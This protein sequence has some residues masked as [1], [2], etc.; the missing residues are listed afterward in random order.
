MT[1]ARCISALSAFGF[2]QRRRARAATPAFSQRGQLV[3]AALAVCF[4]GMVG[5]FSP[6]SAQQWREIQPQINANQARALRPKVSSILNSGGDLSDADMK[7]L[8]QYFKQYEFPA[9]TLTDDAS[10]GALSE[11]RTRLFRQYL[12]LPRLSQSARDYLNGLTLA[13][14]GSVAVGNYHPAVRYNA[15]L[16][17]GQLE[18]QPAKS[19]GAA[20]VPLVKSTDALLKLLEVDEFKGVKVPSSVRV[21]ALVGLERQTQFGVDPQYADRIAKAALAVTTR[22][23]LPEDAS[24]DVYDWMRSIAVRVLANQFAKGLTPPVY[25]ALVAVVADEKI[26]LDDRCRIAQSLS[27]AMFAGAK[28]IDAAKMTLALGMLAKNVLSTEAKKADKYQEALLADPNAIAAAGAGGGFGGGR[29]GYGRGGFGGG[30]GGEEDPSL[31]TGPHYEKR[32]MLARILAVASAANALKNTADASDEVKK[33]LDDL[34]APIMAVANEASSKDATEVNVARAVSSLS[35]DVATLV[36]GWNGVK[37]KPA[38][39]ADN[40]FGAVDQK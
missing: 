16:V 4:V 31:D 17:I 13:A 12:G 23:D 37:P 28:G 30:F 38:N 32:Q 15:A 34:R 20:P 18:Q 7:T 39:D 22:K 6:A 9:M 21:A 8:D 35:A 26:N 25:D 1:T 2:R 29:G 19:A 27:P 14:M 40:A 10:L 36:D 11:A 3:R 33:R 24:A 5:G